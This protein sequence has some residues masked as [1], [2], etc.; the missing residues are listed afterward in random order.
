MPRAL[1]IN[2]ARK[3]AKVCVG[4]TSIRQQLEVRHGIALSPRAFRDLTVVS[5]KRFRN[6]SRYK[7]IVDIRYRRSVKRIGHENIEQ[8]AK[9]RLLHY[10]RDRCSSDDTLWMQRDDHA[11][12]RGLAK[13]PCNLRA[14]TT[15]PRHERCKNDAHSALTERC[16]VAQSAPAH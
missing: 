4:F 6:A 11:K 16:S 15:D 14:G 2:S 1:T 9:Y 7:N 12:V 10:L 5:D 13:S 8:N 3:S